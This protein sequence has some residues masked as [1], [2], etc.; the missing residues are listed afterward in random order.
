LEEWL[1]RDLAYADLRAVRRLTSGLLKLL[2]PGECWPTDAFEKLAALAVELRRSVAKLTDIPRTQP[3]TDTPRDTDSA[4]ASP[5]WTERT[6]VD[7]EAA[8]PLLPPEIANNDH[9]PGETR[10]PQ[11][12]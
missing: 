6:P 2:Y 4:L 10:D 1:P 11:S 5:D 12:S 8:L 3:A 9:L 7:G